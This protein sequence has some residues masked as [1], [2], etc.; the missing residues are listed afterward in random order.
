[1]VFF[2]V[3]YSLVG[4]HGGLDIMGY[5]LGQFVVRAIITVRYR[6][7]ACSALPHFVRPLWANPAEIYV[8]NGLGY[9][10]G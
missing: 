8:V 4:V 10:Y 2:G 6:L 9:G 3:Q 5:V 1:M 7:L